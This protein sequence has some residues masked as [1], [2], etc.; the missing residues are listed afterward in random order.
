MA[1]QVSTHNSL[2]G[3]SRIGDQLVASFNANLNSRGGNCNVEIN[4]LQLFQDHQTEVRNDIKQF[5]SHY[6]DQLAGM[7]PTADFFE[8]IE[9]FK[10]NDPFKDDK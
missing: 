3:S 4:N 1:I 9:E 5:Y 2:V 8:P 10:Y 7:D 6:L